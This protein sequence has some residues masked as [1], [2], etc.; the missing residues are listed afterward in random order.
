M[1]TTPSTKEEVFFPTS[2]EYPTRNPDRT[3]QVL[4][5]LTAAREKGIAGLELATYEDA[6]RLK[7]ALYARLKREGETRYKVV[8]RRNKIFVVGN[9]KLAE[10]REK[11]KA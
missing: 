2:I 8:Q 5:V 10:M 4:R 9:V 3:K 7:S 1:S 6:I 11:G